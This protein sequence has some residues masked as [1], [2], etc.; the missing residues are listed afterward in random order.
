[1]GYAQAIALKQE[2]LEVEGHAEGCW[3]KL[4]VREGGGGGGERE[5]EEV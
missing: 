3:A 4:Q 1:M 2:K 5:D